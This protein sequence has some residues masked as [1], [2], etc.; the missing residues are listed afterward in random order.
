MVHSKN[1]GNLFENKTL[2][3]LKVIDGM[4]HKTLGSGNSKDDKGDLACLHFLIE[5]KHQ[6][7]LS[8]GSL[9]KFWIKIVNEAVNIDKTPLL[10][11]KENNKP[12]MVRF[13]CG[14]THITHMMYW[15]EFY[16]LLKEV[17]L[18]G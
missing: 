8:K 16:D 13:F 3:E 18:D 10:V 11:Y 9:D 15:Q 7:T 6:K 12:T 4:S 1:K 17:H 5:C 14:K 2:K